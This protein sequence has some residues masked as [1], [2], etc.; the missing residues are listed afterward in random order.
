MDLIDLIER[1]TAIPGPSGFE[2]AVAIAIRSELE[3]LDGTIEFD[4]IGNL[5]LRMPAEQ[6][7]PRLLIAA[8][9]DEVGLLVGFI[10][11]D[12]M[13]YC[14]RNGFIDERTLPGSRIEI[15]TDAGPVLGIVG[16]K[17]RHQVTAA[18][19]ARAPEVE[20]LW[21]DVGAT[22][23]D[24]VRALGIRIGQPATTWSPL[25]RLGDGL[26]TGKAIDNRAGCAVLI[27][28]AR[29]VAGRARDYELVFAW[30]TQEEVG[31]RG[32]R[33]LAQWLDPTAAVVV[34]TMPAG[35]DSTPR[36]R[37]TARVGEGPVIRAQDTRATMGTLY[38][39]AVRR[40]LEDAAEALDIPF[41]V[42]CYPTW[43]DAC[44]IHLGGRGV[45]TGGLFLPRRC[46]HS[47]NEVIDVAD[48]TRAIDL[49]VE[50][51]SIDA[52]TVH[53]FTVRPAFALGA[54]V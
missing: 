22:S 35:D 12:G 34:D 9:M 41:Q 40:R 18:D 10:A 20:D 36:H 27:E 51:T 38:S 39:Q 45:P 24:G 29:A 47:A 53:G 33:V 21:I 15:W 13:L 1:L 30:A 14:A 31:S 19:L 3:G 37:A 50:L 43:T 48:I 42:D 44:E 28:V 32:A 11:D 49:L 4:A 8:H 2:D 25:R 23:A 46:A 17:S 26:I 16:A 5:V 54:G 7:A 6:G 52:E